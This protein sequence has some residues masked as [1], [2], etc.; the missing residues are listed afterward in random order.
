M[1]QA[2]KYEDDHTHTAT[3]ASKRNTTKTQAQPRAN[4][5]PETGGKRPHR[6]KPTHAKQTTTH[7]TDEARTAASESGT[8]ARERGLMVR[9]VRVFEDKAWDLGDK[10]KGQFH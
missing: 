9:G 5:A 8:A 6:E 10:A 4:K 1:E 2:V 3:K 7:P